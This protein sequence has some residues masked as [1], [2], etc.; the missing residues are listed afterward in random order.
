MGDAYH[1]LGLGQD[2]VL[3][4]G[5]FGRKNQQVRPDGFAGGPVGRID[6]PGE[7]DLRHH[8]GRGGAEQLVHGPQR[9]AA[10]QPLV[11]L[12]DLVF[13]ARHRLDH[14]ARLDVAVRAYRRHDAPRGQ[15]VFDR[16]M[17]AVAVVGNLVSAGEAIR[18]PGSI[19]HAAGE[20][21]HRAG[22]TRGERGPAGGDGG[23]VCRRPRALFCDLLVIPGPGGGQRAPPLRFLPPVFGLRGLEAGPRLRRQPPVAGGSAEQTVQPARARGREIVPVRAGGPGFKAG[24][25]VGRG[26]PRRD[27]EPAEADRLE[28]QHAGQ[29]LVQALDLLRRRGGLFARGPLPSL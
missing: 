20:P 16:E 18:V 15:F 6:V 3:P 11:A 27:H 22:I 8:I 24:A 17:P 12:G 28:R 21:F 10:D 14:V 25:G 4:D 23:V 9:D 26:H 2:Q 1:G 19:E 13:G 7:G 5:P 29:H